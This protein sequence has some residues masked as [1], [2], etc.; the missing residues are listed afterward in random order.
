MSLITP[1]STETLLSATGYVV[2][3]T[4]IIIIIIITSVIITISLYKYICQFANH[5]THCDKGKVKCIFTSY[6]V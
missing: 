4:I 6:N 1:N 5:T 3:I 2:I